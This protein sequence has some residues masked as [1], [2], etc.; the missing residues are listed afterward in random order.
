MFIK[1]I[2]SK[3]KLKKAN[4]VKIFIDLD[5]RFDDFFLKISV[6]KVELNICNIKYFQDSSWLKCAETEK[7]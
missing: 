2:C 4:V 1:Y 5:E 3:E 7:N 6:E